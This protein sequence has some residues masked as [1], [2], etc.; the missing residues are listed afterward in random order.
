MSHP[1]EREA[2]SERK[3]KVERERRSL[4]NGGSP[5]KKNRVI[6][7]ERDRRTD[8]IGEPQVE[9]ESRR[10]R[11]SSRNNEKEKDLKL[12]MGIQKYL[13]IIRVQR[14]SQKE[15]TNEKKKRV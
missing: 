15:R 2:G 11:E 4:G 6:E 8:R 5:G 10:R 9:K 7:S 13:F 3:K 14:E 12:L 1:R